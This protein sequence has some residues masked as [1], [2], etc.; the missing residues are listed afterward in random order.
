MWF[1]AE[2]RVSEEKESCVSVR[3]RTSYKREREK[4]KMISKRRATSATLW[5][6]WRERERDL[7]RRARIGFLLVNYTHTPKGENKSASPQI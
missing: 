3:G 6:K 5:Y 4:K 7:G 1:G 2:A